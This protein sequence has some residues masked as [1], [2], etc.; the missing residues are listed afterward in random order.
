M[1]N[2]KIY[3]VGDPDYDNLD[4][5][6]ELEWENS[7]VNEFMQSKDIGAVALARRK[8]IAVSQDIHQIIRDAIS[9]DIDLSTHVSSNQLSE[10]IRVVTKPLTDKLEFKKYQINNRLT[11]GLNK[12]IPSLVVRCW[13]KFGENGSGLM[14]P[15]PAIL[16]KVKPKKALF[17][18]EI[19]DFWLTP[20]I[21][22]YFKQGQELDLIRRELPYMIDILDAG[23]EEY[24]HL[25]GKRYEQ[26]LKLAGKLYNVTSLKD[27]LKKGPLLYRTYIEAGIQD[28]TDLELVLRRNKLS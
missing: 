17:S 11:I 1:K 26:E 21:P 23:I 9:S 15:A 28:M 18:G 13:K 25:L 7:K 24:Y 20:D 10:L 2:L 16:Y 12:L 14:L 22:R 3:D 8:K 5:I 4:S 27:L 6:G 19:L